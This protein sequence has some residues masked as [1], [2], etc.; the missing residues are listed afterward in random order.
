M[1]ETWEVVAYDWTTDDVVETFRG[2]DAER[3]ARAHAEMLDGLSLRCYARRK[4]V[5]IAEESSRG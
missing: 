2:D 3:R 4:R 5:I 1:T